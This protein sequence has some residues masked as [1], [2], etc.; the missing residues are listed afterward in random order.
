MEK[1]FLSEI[2][3]SIQGETSLSGIMTSFVR[4]SGCPLRC[5]WCDSCYS[6]QEGTLST[7][8]TLFSAL[9]NFGWKYVCI[10]GG[11]PLLQ[12]PVVPFMDALLTKGYT[13][14]LETCGSLSTEL[15]P[16][17]VITILD[18]KCPGSGM[19]HKNLFE[20]LFRLRQH[21]QVK[22]VLVDRAD[23]DFAKDILSNYDLWS[24]VST[25]L[26]SPAWGILPPEELV[27]WIKEEK[28]P[29]RLNLQL[30]KYIWGPS[31]RGV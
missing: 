17:K 15:V 16:E 19:S 27:A 29:V 4:L 26:F 6:F 13:V 24:K 23:F 2:F 3:E 28:L 14:S 12:K 8:D 11:E 30:H 1:L 25:I 5:S 9:E 18:I 31:L 10:T 20:N 7:F 22:F 21:D